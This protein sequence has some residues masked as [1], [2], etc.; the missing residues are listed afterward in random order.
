MSTYRAS[1]LG[2]GVNRYLLQR[3]R[4][5]ERE[6]RSIVQTNEFVKRFDYPPLTD[7]F[8]R[9]L[10]D[11]SVDNGVNT[12][13]FISSIRMLVQGKYCRKM[14]PSRWGNWLVNLLVRD[15]FLC[16]FDKG[17]WQNKIALPEVKDILLTGGVGTMI[18]HFGLKIAFELLD[19]A[20]DGSS[21]IYEMIID[22]YDHFPADDPVFLE[23]FEGLINN[24]RYNT[25]AFAAKKMGALKH[26]SF[27]ES[28][29]RKAL[30]SD[31]D[32]VVREAILAFGEMNAPDVCNILT[33]RFIG[34]KIGEIFPG[35]TS[36]AYLMQWDNIKKSALEALKSAANQDAKLPFENVFQ[37]PRDYFY[38]GRGVKPEWA[39]GA[40]RILWQIGDERSHNILINLLRYNR[41][42]KLREAIVEGIG[43]YGDEKARE[44]LERYGVEDDDKNVRLSTVRCLRSIGS[45]RSVPI[46]ERLLSDDSDG[47]RDNAAQALGDLKSSGSINLLIKL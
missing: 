17:E 8:D 4:S 23:H 12:Y 29:K 9:Y 38:L 6:S 37:N 10:I 28:L 19:E 11:G 1:W 18:G 31:D 45:D 21:T 34:S 43:D 30:S 14:A 26:P 5:L 16:L 22:E 13:S 15:G 41:D 7:S 2:R 27:Y 33:D 32:L 20:R 46:F 44:V 47:V 25:R 3:A 24:S 35:Y 40:A 36:L 39:S 42:P